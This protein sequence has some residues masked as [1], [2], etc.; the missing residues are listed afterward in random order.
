MV[1]GLIDGSLIWLCGFSGAGKTSLAKVLK[2]ELSK[3]DL[4]VILLDGD[5]MRVSLESLTEIMELD[6]YSNKGRLALAKAYARLGANLVEQNTLVIV[7]TIS[8]IEEVFQ[9]N[10]QLGIKYF[11]VF[12]DS[13]INK[14]IKK[15][16]KNLYGNKNNKLVG[17]DISAYVPL[18]A[19]LKLKNDFET[20]LADLA[21]EILKSFLTKYPEY[22]RN[23]TR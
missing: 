9:F 21:D 15:D 16:P 12:L 22:K 5:A 17:R 18:N 8:L 20:S 10:R 14:I 13:D 19:D 1:S 4:N 7:S 3:L 11:E 23:G 6:S 2:V